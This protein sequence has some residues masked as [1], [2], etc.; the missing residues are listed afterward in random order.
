M[1]ED[2]QRRLFSKSEKDILYIASDGKCE[3]CG[4]P[5]RPRLPRRP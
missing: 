4:K 1:V 3:I 2:A 5:L